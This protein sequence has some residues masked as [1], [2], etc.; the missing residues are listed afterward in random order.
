MPT[1]K[2][3]TPADLGDQLVRLVD[4]MQYRIT[5]DESGETSDILDSMLAIALKLTGEWP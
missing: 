2:T 3:E 4:R 5:E 1:A